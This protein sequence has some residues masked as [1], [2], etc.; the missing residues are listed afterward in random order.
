M[1]LRPVSYAASACDAERESGL[2]LGEIVGFEPM[3]LLQ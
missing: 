3:K 1:P 2:S